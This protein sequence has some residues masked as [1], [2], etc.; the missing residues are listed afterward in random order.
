MQGA[1][2]EQH[3]R[4]G[5]RVQ[6]GGVLRARGAAGRGGRHD[7]RQEQVA[8]AGAAVGVLRVNV[9]ARRVHLACRAKSSSQP[10][11]RK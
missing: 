5:R 9:H 1:P 10:M 8:L 6:R 11:R 4:A 3:E 7:R 2:V